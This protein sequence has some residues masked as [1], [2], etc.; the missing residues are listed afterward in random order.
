MIDRVEIAR[1]FTDLSIAAGRE[2]LAVRQAGVETRL[3]NGVEPVTEADT[4][5]E[6]VILLGLARALPDIPVIAE[7]QTADQGLG[8]SADSFILVDPVDGTKEFISGRDDFT[9]NIALI[10]SGEPVV[11]VVFAPMHNEVFVG[12]HADRGRAAFRLTGPDYDVKDADVLATRQYGSEGLVAT[13]SRS[14]R[15]PQTDEFL[16][17]LNISGT[18]A[19][20]SSLKFC[21]IAQ[22]KAD[23]YPRFGPT[24]EWDTAAAHAVLTAAGGRVLCP[25]GKPFVYNKTSTGFRNGFFVAWGRERLA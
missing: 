5:A 23:V 25:E 21:R 18:D 16:Q 22:G 12:I 19:S 24:M 14:H 9:V 10:V 2:I 11:G 20:G 13:V 7:E 6:A 17:K 8:A 4:R 15:D 3:K 1:L